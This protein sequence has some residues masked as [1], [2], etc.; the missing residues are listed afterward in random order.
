[1]KIKLLLF[2]QLKDV[3]QNSEIMI[4]SIDDTRTL[5]DILTK[6]YPELSKI[7]FA[8]ALNQKIVDG[9]SVL[10]DND[11]VALL[12]AFSGG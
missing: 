11:V 3:F 1:M 4:E 9:K 10:K 8:I 2:G 5:I 12:P 7:T 6:Q